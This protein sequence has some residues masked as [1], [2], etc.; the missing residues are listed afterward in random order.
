[1]DPSGQ[2]SDWPEHV[3][4]PLRPGMTLG[5]YELLVPVATGGMACVWAA[6]L[7]GHRG[8]TKRVA[9][10]T[11]LAHLTHHRDFENMLLDEAR[12]AA[13]AH[14][15]NVCN[16]FD[17]GEEHGI[18]YL[19]LE[20][21]NGDSLLQVLRG[22]RPR[23]TAPLDYRIA[24][25]VVADACAGLHAAHELTDGRGKS[26]DVVHRDISPHNLLV[27]LEGTT[28][29][30][31]FGIA[32]AHGQLHQTTRTGE[33]R[34]KFA[35]MA[36]EQMNGTALDRRADIFGMGAVLYHATTGLAPFRG[37]SDAR[38]I[39][40][41]IAGDYEP[42]GLVATDYPPGLAAIAT[43]ALSP[44][45]EDRFPTAERMQN[46]LE[47]WL[48][49]SGHVTTAHDVAGVVR[50]RVGA[51]LE[52]RREEVQA[53][54]DAEQMARPTRAPRAAPRLLE[55]GTIRS[56]DTPGGAVS[57]SVPLRD[58]SVPLLP[59][60]S[61]ASPGSPGAADPVVP[62]PRVRA[63]RA[64]KIAIA[65]ALGLA[66][67]AVVLRLRSRAGHADFDRDPATAQFG[68]SSH[69]ASVPSTELPAPPPATPAPATS[70]VSISPVAA[71][72]TTLAPTPTQAPAPVRAPSA[73]PKPYCDP[74][75]SFDAQGQK[76]F[77]P[78][79]YR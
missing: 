52:R 79:C 65:V 66:I 40:A 44:R 4:G 42:P 3:T 15:P 12:I 18:L 53:A 60:R 26:L 73:A 38:I 69:P 76:H 51:K 46:A 6:Q 13:G 32:K 30:A 2:A 11:I 54:M 34:G 27:S 74:P 33:V 59:Q 68:P 21:V 70:V 48:V 23:T 61:H 41:V 10:K 63:P 39:R 58:P 49:G 1:M 57:A 64:L 28:K 77:K 55:S 17:A 35:Y 9:I 50:A 14:H 29:V 31:D 7:S 43:R 72:A 22:P 16:L 20:W 78:A 45:A 62:L 5:R 37:D 36:P 67:A 8:F 19:V 71:S 24:A 56:T 47:A 25:R 75:Y